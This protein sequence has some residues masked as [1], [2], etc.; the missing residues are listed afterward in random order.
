MILDFLTVSTESLKFYLPVWLDKAAQVLSFMKTR[1]VL[2]MTSDHSPD[3]MAEGVAMVKTE[4][5]KTIQSR[6]EAKGLGSVEIHDQEEKK[7]IEVLKGE[8]A[9]MSVSVNKEGWLNLIVSRLKV[10]PPPH[11]AP[12]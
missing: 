6:R 5:R 4:L 1:C 9:V 3:E 12:Q 7:S 8:D 11:E 10:V 2:R